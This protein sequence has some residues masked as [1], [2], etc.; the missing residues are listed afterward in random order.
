MIKMDREIM[1]WSSANKNKEMNYI[2]TAS[3]A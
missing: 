3:E 1:A 2:K